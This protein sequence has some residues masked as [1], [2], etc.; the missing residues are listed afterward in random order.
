MVLPEN[1][2]AICRFYTIL[3]KC[4]GFVVVVALPETITNIGVGQKI[5]DIITPV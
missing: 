4:N 1:L 5:P 2:E 3:L